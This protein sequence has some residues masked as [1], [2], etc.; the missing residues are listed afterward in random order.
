MVA[1]QYPHWSYFPRNTHPPDWVGQFVHVVESVAAQIDTRDE[2]T[3]LGL[4]SDGV[5]AALR[6]GLV[7]QGYL[8]ESG[9]AAA[10]KIKRPVLFGDNGVASVSYEL[11]AFHP[12]LGIAVEIEAGRGAANNADYRDIV[13]TSLILD[14]EYLV[15]GMPIR[16]RFK[17]GGKTNAT[18]AFE[19]TR[20]RLEAIY[21]SHRLKLPFKGVLLV[22]Y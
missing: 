21:S 17:N 13:R 1:R 10:E 9:K 14:A 15:L 6:P 16:Y 5:L 3:S 20:A 8:V 18:R 22:G 12:Q 19:N 4:T 7:T 2:T 11:D